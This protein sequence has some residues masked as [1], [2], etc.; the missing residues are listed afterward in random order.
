MKNLA[1][2][3]L[4]VYSFVVT[5]VFVWFALKIVN[6]KNNTKAV[7]DVIEVKQ[8]RIVEPDGTLRMVLSNHDKFPGI[9]VK[10]K[11]HEFDRPRAGMLFYND[12]GSEN[13]GLI[14][15][16]YMDEN[17]KI[18]NA[19]GSLTFDRY[20]GDQELQL[21]GVHDSEDAITGLIVRDS[22]PNENGYGR[23]WLGKDRE[24]TASLALKDGKGNDRILLKVDASGDASI[25]FLDEN[26]NVQNRILPNK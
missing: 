4:V 5:I 6:S 11:E 10:G 22:P 9:I 17:G 20:G 7:F 21:M 15:S 8:I 1:Q 18:M 13:G 19:G 24:G 25:V 23:L 3:F 16:G 26:G 2:K 14:F 12:E